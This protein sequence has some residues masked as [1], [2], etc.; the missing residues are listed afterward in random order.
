MKPLLAG[1][2]AVSLLLTTSALAQS[3]SECASGWPAGAVQGPRPLT[4]GGMR[5]LIAFTRLLG[6]VRHFHPSD[7]AAAADWDRLAIEGVRRLEAC[8]GPEQLAAALAA[9]FR[10]VAPTVQVFPTGAQPPLPAE[11]VPAGATGLK[12][13]SWRHVGAGQ[14]ALPLGRYNES[15]YK[16]ERISAPASSIQPFTG[17]PIP[18]HI[19]SADLGAGVSARVPLKLYADA[20]GIG[21]RLGVRWLG[22]SVRT[23]PHRSTPVPDDKSPLSANRSQCPIGGGGAGVERAS[24]LLP[25]FRCGQYRLARC[26]GRRAFVRGNRCRGGGARRHAG[27][28]GGRPA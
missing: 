16:S 8:E 27:A 25:L 12:V 15:F 11:L 5:N 2:L 18:A 19:F 17:G 6:Y 23:L 7:Q 14:V 20:T 13:V 28:S 10:S 1:S 4:E 3:P 9:F 21:C 24:A 26:A 22:C